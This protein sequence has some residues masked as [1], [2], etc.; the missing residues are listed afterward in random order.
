MFDLVVLDL[1]MPILDGYDTCISIRSL[2]D[3]HLVSP[4][5]NTNKRLNAQ[6]NEVPLM[7]A[8]TADS[9]GQV[10][11]A[12]EKAGFDKVFCQLS[13]MD[14]ANILVTELTRRRDKFNAKIERSD[15]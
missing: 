3:L 2:F 4:K 7:V 10:K 9:V 15:K 8:N 13:A 6:L 12:C 14:I 5:F 11:R 1:N